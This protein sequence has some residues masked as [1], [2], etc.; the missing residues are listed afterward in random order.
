MAVGETC[1]RTFQKCTDKIRQLTD[2]EEIHHCL[3]LI[4]ELAKTST[5]MVDLK[6]QFADNLLDLIEDMGQHLPR[7]RVPFYQY[8]LNTIAKR[9]V[10]KTKEVLS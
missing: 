3:E 5:E 8:R 1:R 4:D 6:I 7:R 10:E 2:D 9:H